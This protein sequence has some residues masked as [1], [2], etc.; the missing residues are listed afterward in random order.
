MD[1][2]GTKSDVFNAIAASTRRDMLRLLADGEM[3]VTE[4]AQSFDMSLSAVSQHLAILREANLVTVTKLGKQ[5]LYRITPDPLLDVADW[6][7]QY[8]RFWTG[9]LERLETYLENIDERKTNIP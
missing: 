2:G 4:I 6:L 5:R 8:D 1:T 9:K 7:T 3:P